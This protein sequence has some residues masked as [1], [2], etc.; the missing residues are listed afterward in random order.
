LLQS[1]AVF[2]LLLE[3][4]IRKSLLPIERNKISFAGRTFLVRCKSVPALL[5]RSG[6]T[7]CKAGSEEGI[8]V[9]YVEPT[10]DTLKL[11]HGAPA[12]DI[13][14]K[15]RA[16]VLFADLVNTHSKGGLKFSSIS[17]FDSRILDKRRIAAPILSLTLNKEVELWIGEK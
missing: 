15:Q 11:G 12:N 7:L 1:T 5:F 6:H 9:T 14:A 16:S 4:I 8:A 10:I 3:I 17:L 13:F 2:F